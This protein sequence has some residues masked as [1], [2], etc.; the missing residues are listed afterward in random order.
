SYAAPPPGAS[1]RVALD[2]VTDRHG[3]LTLGVAGTLATVAGGGQNAGDS[4]EARFVVYGSPDFVSNSIL[5]FQGNSDLLLN[6]MDWLAAQQ[7]FITIR[8]QAPTSAPVNLSA[9]QMSYIFWIFL[10]GLPL[11]MV[12]GGTAMWL[13]RRRL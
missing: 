13:R 6:T 8:P 10:V 11:L 7:N 12:V 5:S 2:P 3:P 1:G 9:G 4:A